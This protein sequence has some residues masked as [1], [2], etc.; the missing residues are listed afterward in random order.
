MNEGTE[1]SHVC[2]LSVLSVHPVSFR[3]ILNKSFGPV[4]ALVGQVATHFTVGEQIQVAFGDF[5]AVLKLV[6]ALGLE[7]A[8]EGLA[9]DLEGL[10]TDSLFTDQGLL[11]ISNLTRIVIV[12]T[13]EGHKFRPLVSHEGSIVSRRSKW[14]VMVAL[15]WRTTR[16][17]AASRSGELGGV[18]AFRGI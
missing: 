15:M 16:R 3:Y 1:Y 18:I 7:A 9:Y 4:V 10:D 12:D 8:L 17:V 11:S 2:I 5:F 6:D 13:V 14:L